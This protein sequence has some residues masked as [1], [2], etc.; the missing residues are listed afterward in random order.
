MR[1][2][3]DCRGCQLPP[4]K[5]LSFKQGRG[6]GEEGGRLGRSPVHSG[7]DSRSPGMW[8]RGSRLHKWLRE[9]MM[10]EGVLPVPLC[11]VSG[12]GECEEEEPAR[13]C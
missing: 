4:A 10:E 12:G 3:G 5:S 1:L 7:S 9:G 6:D 2:K 11:F 8:P 13:S